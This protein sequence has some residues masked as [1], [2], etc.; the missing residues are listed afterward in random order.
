MHSR[1][2]LLLALLAGGGYQ[3]GVKPRRQRLRESAVLPRLIGHSVGDGRARAIDA[4]RQSPAKPQRVAVLKDVARLAGVDPSTVS[5][6]LRGDERKPAKAETRERILQVA[7][8]MGYRAN[9]VARSLRTKQREAIGLVIPDAAN[10]GFAEIFKG[11]QAVTAEAGWHVIVVEGRPNDRPDLGWDRIVLEGRVDGVLVL[12]ASIRDRVVKRVAESGFPIVLVNRRSNGVAGSVVMNDQ[13]GSDVAVEHF[14]ALGHRKIGHIAGP[15][16]L[17][18]GRRRLAGFRDALKKRKLVAREEW[19]TETDYTEAGGARAARA[20]IER[21]DGDLP[22]AVYIASF[23][24]GVGAI[25]VFKEAGL[26]V[27]D[28][29]SVIVSDE[30]SLAAHTAPPLTTVDMPVTRMGEVAAHMLLRAVAGEPVSDIVL[31][32]APR[33]VIRGSTAPPR[34]R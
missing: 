5:R 31:P 23:M 12:V 11:V 10:P 20:L 18:T 14:F 22:T 29:I 3:R 9:S 4:L 7:R 25:Q 15:A 24:S 2:P 33:L 6:V 26:S 32:D 34:G 27:P 8:E 19:I 28:D 16:N 1:A 17:D 30:L 13:R 21:S